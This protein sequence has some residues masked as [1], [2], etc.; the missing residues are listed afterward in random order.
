M[1]PQTHYKDMHFYEKMLL[2]VVCAQPS[3][4][5]KPVC[6]EVNSTGIALFLAINYAQHITELP[7]ISCDSNQRRGYLIKTKSNV[8]C[9]AIINMA[10]FESRKLPLIH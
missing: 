4:Y 5:K 8:I 10:V 6:L 2:S 1:C 3:C 7:C 9:I